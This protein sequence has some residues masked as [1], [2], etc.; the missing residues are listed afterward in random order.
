MLIKVYKGLH[1]TEA[2]LTLPSP[3][4]A[5]AELATQP[6]AGKYFWR[7]MR[8]YFAL[9]GNPA[10]AQLTKVST[11]HTSSSILV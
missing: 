10:S 8:Q 6:F 5:C 4:Q 7:P 1:A 2:W 11:F 3:P 9:F